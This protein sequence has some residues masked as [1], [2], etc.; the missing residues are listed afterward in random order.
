MLRRAFDMSHITRESRVETQD[1]DNKL[2]MLCVCVM[3]VTYVNIIARLLLLRY[4]IAML[5]VT[6]CVC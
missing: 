5:G 3:T 1:I 2:V 6:V 4:M